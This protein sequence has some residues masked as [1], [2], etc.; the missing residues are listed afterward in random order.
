MTAVPGT[1]AGK[2]PSL[3]IHAKQVIPGNMYSLPPV[4]ENDKKIE[5]LKPKQHAEM[6]T[7]MTPT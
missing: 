5:D 6:A 4:N 3:E 1:K 7:S 2:F